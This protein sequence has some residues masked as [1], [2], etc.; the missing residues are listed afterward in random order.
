MSDKGNPLIR[1]RQ[2]YS[3]IIFDMDGVLADSSPAHAGAFEELWSRLGIE[4]PSYAALAGR[5]TAEA[6]TDVTRALAPSEAAL[7]EWISFK[8]AE[9]R[10]RLAEKSSLFADTIPVLDAIQKA[11]ISCAVATGASRVTT[12]LILAPAGGLSRFCS[13]I[14]AEDVNVGKPAPDTYL[15]VLAETGVPAGQCLVVEDS[16]AGL[17]AGLD[18]GAWVSSVRTGI[19]ARHDRFVDSFADLR[20]LLGLLGLEAPCPGS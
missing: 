7:R 2:P 18:A 6:I 15:K 9:A 14:A 11:G 4:G 17:R 10:R 16:V 1:T 8:Q 19:T 12:E 5:R 13:V 3:L 20:A